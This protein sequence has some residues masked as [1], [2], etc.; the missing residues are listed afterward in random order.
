M[1][2]PAPPPLKGSPPRADNSPGQVEHLPV[3]KAQGGKRR[4]A[5]ALP[6]AAGAEGEW[7]GF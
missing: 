6:K 2:R 7:A 5:A 3:G 4:P 1:I